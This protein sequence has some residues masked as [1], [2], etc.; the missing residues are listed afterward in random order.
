MIWVKMCK[1]GGIEEMLGE[2][3]DFFLVKNIWRVIDVLVDVCVLMVLF[4]ELI[5][6]GL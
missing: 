2:V 3:L 5:L 4:E 6:F 1:I